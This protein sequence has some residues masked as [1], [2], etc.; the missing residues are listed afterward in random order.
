MNPPGAVLATHFPA[1]VIGIKVELRLVW[2]GLRHDG[3]R[4]GRVVARP[5]VE[6]QRAHLIQKTLKNLY[7]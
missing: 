2:T 7:F 6:N 1:R 4:R 5:R 3:A